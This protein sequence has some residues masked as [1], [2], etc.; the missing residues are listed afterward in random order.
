MV[1]IYP[2]H[3]QAAILDELGD[4]VLMDPESYLRGERNIFLRTNFIRRHS[5]QDRSS[6]TISGGK[7]PRM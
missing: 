4:Q 2:E 1:S 3:S 6:S 5:Q 7:Q